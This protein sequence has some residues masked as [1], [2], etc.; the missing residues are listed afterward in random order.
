MYREIYITY[1]YVYMLHTNLYV[2]WKVY[3]A[4]QIY[5]QSQI[6]VL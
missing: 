1:E 2:G 3:I 4:E 6:S 5:Q